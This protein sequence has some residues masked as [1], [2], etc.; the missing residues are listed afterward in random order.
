MDVSYQWTTGGNPVFL[1]FY[2]VTE[3]YYSRIAGGEEN[4]RVYS[5]LSTSSVSAFKP[6]TKPLELSSR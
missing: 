4:R 5:M 1:R 2:A 3:A 6:T